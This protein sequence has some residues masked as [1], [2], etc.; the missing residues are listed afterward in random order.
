MKVL[1]FTGMPCS[2][3]TEA[4]KVAKEMGI[5]VIRMGDM[6]W[7]EVKN[8]GLPLDNKN[9]G[10]VADQM[11]NEH[12][13]DIWARR[14]L[15]KIRIL[16]KTDIIVI[17]GIRNVEE[18][19]TFKKK[20]GKEFIVIVITASDETRRKRVLDRGRQDDSTNIEDLEE[21]DKRELRWGLGAVIAAADVV[22]SN[23][24]SIDEFRDKIRKTLDKI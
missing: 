11:R 4:V 22:I 10:N 19:D 5:P 14:A 7:E 12:G 3:K 24:G 1:A 8:R 20:L 13:K 21:R 15:T 23:E 18:I 2:G 6:V 17:D 16:D 9:V